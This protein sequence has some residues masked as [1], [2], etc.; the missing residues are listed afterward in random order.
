MKRWPAPRLVL[1]VVV[2]Y[3]AAA[4]LEWQLFG[5]AVLAIVALM[6][7]LMA[8]V[9]LRLVVFAGMFCDWRERR[10]PIRP[11]ERER[12]RRER[13][14]RRRARADAPRRSS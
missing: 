13:E 1:L 6:L 7:A 11:E 9:A 12:R 3:G 4:V 5:T 10:R 14:E 8:T 2:S